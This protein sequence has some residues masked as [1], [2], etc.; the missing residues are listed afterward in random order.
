MITYT[1]AANVTE[2]GVGPT[3]NI[4]SQNVELSN[5]NNTGLIHAYQTAPNGSNPTITQMAYRLEGSFDG[6]IWAPIVATASITGNGGSATTNSANGGVFR[7]CA[8][9]PYMRF[10]C[11]TAPATTSGTT[12][13]GAVLSF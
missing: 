9:A 13:G 4:T 11:T 5:V 6:T 2:T 8:L 1:L 12:F 7:T 3:I 10:V